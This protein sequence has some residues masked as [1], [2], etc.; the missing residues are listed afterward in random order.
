[1]FNDFMFITI[2][3]MFFIVL[4]C[5]IAVPIIGFYFFSLYKLFEKCEIEG[6]KGLIPFYNK[7]VQ[8]KI[9]GLNWWYIIIY[10]VAIFLYIDGKIGIKILSIL[11]IL[12]VNSIISYN[13]CKK[14]NNG[15]N[16]LFIDFIL[17]TFLPFLYLPVMALN[18]QFKYHPNAEVTSNAYIDEIQ[19]SNYKNKETTKKTNNRKK[20]CEKCGEPL[21]LK[22]IFCP[23][24]GKKL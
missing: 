12:F 10:V 22:D 3:I 20:Y 13:L 19:S 21:A 4:I 23:H 16:S 6:W 7:F 14:I 5:I 18:D 17:L 8:I 15:K 1:M 9:A 2:P 24:C 11:V